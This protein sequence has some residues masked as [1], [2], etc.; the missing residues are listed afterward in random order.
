MSLI[1]QP[2]M[3]TIPKNTKMNLRIHSG[4][5]GNERRRW[6]ELEGRRADMSKRGERMRRGG[7]TETR[8]AA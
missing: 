7:G 5:Q 3:K 2:G 1:S 4:P 8:H 6:A